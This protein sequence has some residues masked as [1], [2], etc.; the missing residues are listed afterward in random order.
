M[1]LFSLKIKY[2]FKQVVSLSVIECVI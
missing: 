2:L 1:Y